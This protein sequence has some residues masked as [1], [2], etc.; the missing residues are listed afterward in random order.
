M[1]KFLIILLLYWF[2]T[3]AQ[4]LTALS[5]LPLTADS[6]LGFDNHGFVYYQVNNALVKSKEN[7]SVDY[8]NFGLGKISR[9]DILNPL[10]VV[11]LYADFNTVALLDNQ[12]NVTLQINFSDYKDPIVVSATGNAS[13]NK[14]W[15]FNELTREIGLYDYLRKEYRVLTQPLIGKIRYYETDFNTFS[16]VN[17]KLERFSCDIYGKITS[18]GLVP[19]FDDIQFVDN[20]SAII[21]IGTKLQH[22]NKEGKINSLTD[23]DE[24]TFKSFYY[25][26]QKLAIFTTDGIKNYK[27][28][29]P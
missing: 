22:I 12:L 3:N 13:R 11:V 15:V 9:V 4:P 28:I 26:P 27:I 23:I 17:D 19:Q 10:S 5:D 20:T 7:K 29:L 8:K 21:R 14:L 2:P 16:W 6:F 1:K 24:K 18:L 25:S